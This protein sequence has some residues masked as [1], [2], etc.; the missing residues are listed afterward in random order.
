MNLYTLFKN[1]KTCP[2]WFHNLLSVV[3]MNHSLSIPFSWQRLPSAGCRYLNLA[4]SADGY[5]FVGTC[6]GLGTVPDTFLAAFQLI[7]VP[8]IAGA[9]NQGLETLHSLFQDPVYRW[10]RQ[11]LNVSKM[12]QKWFTSKA[13]KEKFWMLLWGLKFEGFSFLSSFIF[14][15]KTLPLR[16]INSFEKLNINIKEKF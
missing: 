5:Y 6:P 15:L 7:F 14:H 4:G 8:T 10:R 2:N 13:W 16:N 9:G 1:C 12:V 11:N 3:C